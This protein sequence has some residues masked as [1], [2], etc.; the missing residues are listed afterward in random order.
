[1]HWNRGDYSFWGGLNPH[2]RRGET[3]LLILVDPKSQGALVQQEIPGLPMAPVEWTVRD[4][5]KL[6]GGLVYLVQAR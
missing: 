1:M 5:A 6:L 4:L 3:K 2:L